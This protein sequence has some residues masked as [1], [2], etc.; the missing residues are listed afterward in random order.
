M[1]L[2]TTAILNDQ[3]MR[4]QKSPRDALSIIFLSIRYFSQQS[5][6]LRGHD[7]HDGPPFC[8]NLVKERATEF[9]EIA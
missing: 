5:F 6:L 1:E 2:A 7:Q 3:L 9:S 8:N 4:E